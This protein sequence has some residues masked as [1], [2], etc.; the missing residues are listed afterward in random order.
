MSFAKNWIIAQIKFY[1]LLVV[2]RDFIY[3]VTSL[4]TKAK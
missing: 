2:V 4:I 1:A 3:Y